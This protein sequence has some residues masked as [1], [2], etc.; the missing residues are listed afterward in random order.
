[1]RRLQNYIGGR[2]GPAASGQSFEVFEPAT[3]SAF[4]L[5][6]DS[7]ERDVAA[8]VAAAS[9]AWVSW[10]ALRAEERGRWLDRIADAL[11]RRAAEFARAESDDT[12]KPLAL[13]AGLDIPR[14]IANFR[15]FAD[16]ATQFS[17]E[18]HTMA[19][20][21]VNYTLRQPLGVVACISPWNL[22]LYLLS[23]KIAPALSAGNCVVAKPSEL[24]PLTASLLGELC[25]ELGLPSGVLNLVHGVG[26]R[27]GQAL[28]DNPRVRAISF[29][30]GTATGRTI[31][32]A[33]ARDFKRITLELGGKNAAVVFADADFD[34]A[35]AGCARA[36]FTN[37]GEICLCGSRLLIEAPIYERFRDA[38]VARVRALKVGDPLEAATDQG[39]LVSEAHMNKVLG[40]I[41]DAQ[42]QGGRVL[43]GG[44]RTTV[45]E[46]RCRN[47]WFVAPTLIE[48]LANDCSVNQEEIFGPVATLQPFTDEADAL[49]RANGTRY[50]LAA[51]LWSRDV[52][53]CHRVAEQ[54]EAG[55]VWV[56]TWLLRDLRTPI[57]GVKH[58]GLGREGGLEALRFFTEPKNV[59]VQYA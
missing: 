23:W 42:R 36:A 3:G 50:G 45:K 8:A 55:V 9:E 59:C 7:D 12:G 10:R 20:S 37:Q 57:G 35:V 18:A 26:A 54:L 16:A 40:A 21:A 58:S 32:T 17:S 1:M 28:I 41:A 25:A 52:A 53:R 11:E 56:N 48:G 38:L 33:A 5:A 24:A 15:Y 6:P 51:S 43:C 27:A 30:G 34:A 22:P 14:A 46:T 31:A 29:T 47:G 39:A 19:G 2:L 49:R 4:A 13:A 44:A